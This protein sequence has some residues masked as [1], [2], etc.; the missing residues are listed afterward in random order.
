MLGVEVGQAEPE[1]AVQHLFREILDMSVD[2]KRWRRARCLACA[3]IPAKSPAIWP[4]RWP[5][6]STNIPRGGL[7]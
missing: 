3:A 1:R 2:T 6:V 7:L 4:I 5:R